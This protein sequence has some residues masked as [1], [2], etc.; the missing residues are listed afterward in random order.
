MC[1]HA[2][3]SDSSGT[4]AARLPGA[5]C[6]GKL[7]R[8]SCLLLLAL[9]CSLA[10]ARQSVPVCCRQKTC[11]CRVY[12]LLHGP[13]KHAAGILTMG[14]R[15][16]GSRAFQSRVYDLLHGP[17]K[18][19]AGILTMG[20]RKSGSRAFQSQLYDLLHG[21]GKHAAGI[22][23]MGKRKSGSRAFQ[24]RVYDLL[25]GPGKHAAGILTMGKRKSGSRAF[26]SRVYDLLH[27]P[28]K[29]AA[30]IL[31]MGKRAELEPEQPAPACRAASPGPDTLLPP[32]TCA[33]KSDPTNTRECLGQLGKDSA[34]GQCGGAARSF[35]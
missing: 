13:G 33:T 35:S 16:S 15:N 18:H 24:S 6:W 14:K 22:L 10:A 30:G 17:G 11:P 21:P 32:A 20:K 29:H 12:D 8:P 31:T 9:L 4:D 28:G 5:L 26:Q 23:T 1:G 3:A 7:H 34:K 27:G 2:S 19:A 25:H